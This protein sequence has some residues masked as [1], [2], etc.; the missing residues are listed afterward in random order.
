MRTTKAPQ[1]PIKAR[2]A[3]QARVAAK[4]KLHNQLKAWTLEKPT[5]PKYL[6]NII[7]QPTQPQNACLRQRTQTPKPLVYHELTT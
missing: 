2:R 4:K 7:K 1:T 6:T 3:A 5:G